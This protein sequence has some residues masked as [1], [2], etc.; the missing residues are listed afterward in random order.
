MELPA[1]PF[2]L[3]ELGAAIASSADGNSLTLVAGP[4]SDW[5]VHPGTGL[6][7]LD[8]PGLVG[9]VEGDFMLSARVEV[10][11]A[12]TFDAGVLA[13]WRDEQTWAKLCFEY[14]PDGEPMVVSVVTR[15]TS[16]DCNSTVVE[17]N[18]V[19]L[20][21]SRIGRELAFHSSGDGATW[22]LVRHFALTGDDAIEVGF[23]AQSPLG[24]GCTARF[25]EVRF[26]AATLADL[27]DGR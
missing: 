25:D 16:D 12:A 15:T 26:S 17:G 24:E 13:L 2:A 21:I 11:F 19:W 7:K 10:E 22:R 20:R 1:L 4:R 3:R 14:S 23:V 6:A 9:R 27:R 18:V 8:A 5:F